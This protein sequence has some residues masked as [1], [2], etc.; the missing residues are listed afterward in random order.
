MPRIE[1]LEWSRERWCEDCFDRE[2][3]TGKPSSTSLSDNPSERS[4]PLPVDPDYWISEYWTRMGILLLQ[5]TSDAAIWGVALEI[6]WSASAFDK[7]SLFY[8]YRGQARRRLLQIPTD[9]PPPPQFEVSFLSAKSTVLSFEGR[10]Y[11]RTTC[12]RLGLMPHRTSCADGWALLAELDLA[13]ALDRVTDRW[14]PRAHVGTQ[15]TASPGDLSKREPRIIRLQVT[16]YARRPADLPSASQTMSELGLTTE[17]LLQ[18]VRHAVD[19]AT[20]K[21]PCAAPV[22]RA[23]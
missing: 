8:R 10:L 22:R 17:H 14:D 2:G 15:L 16:A 18:Q 6:F 23:A 3:V 12:V 21:A 1:A 9:P 20:R 4:D 11:A 19:N 5:M 13:G 7:R